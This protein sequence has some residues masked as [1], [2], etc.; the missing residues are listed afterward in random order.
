MPI[1]YTVMEEPENL[2]RHAEEFAQLTLWFK[3]KKKQLG[4]DE[5]ASGDY[6]DMHHPYNQHAEALFKEATLTWQA[7]REYTPSPGQLMAAFF[8][9]PNPNRR[10]SMDA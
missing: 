4:L 7:Q 10:V 1:T 2:E 5:V 6:Y 8:A 9:L 3:T